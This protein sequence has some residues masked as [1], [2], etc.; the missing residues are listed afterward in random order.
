MLTELDPIAIVAVAGFSVCFAGLL[1]LLLAAPRRDCFFLRWH[2]ET[3]FLALVFAPSLL[4][5]WP[6]VLLYW[7][8][9]AGVL[10]D[11]PDFYDD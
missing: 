4:I 2:P 10:P 3:R 11:D 9:R 7:L 8:M 6:L 1:A 5:V